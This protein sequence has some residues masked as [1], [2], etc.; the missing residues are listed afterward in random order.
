MRRLKRFFLISVLLL[1]VLLPCFSTSD[2]AKGIYL[3]EEN[4][5]ML[6]T[7]LQEQS[8]DLQTLQLHNQNYQSRIQDLEKLC[9]E[10]ENLLQK[11]EQTLQ[12][13]QQSSTELKNDLLSVNQSLQNALQAVKHEQSRLLVA[14]IGCVVLSVGVAS[15]AFLL[16]YNTVR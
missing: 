5:K 11:Q 15:L 3:S 14:E 9:V 10:K 4:Y 8:I 2:S 12:T 13:M 7:T 16:V 1:Q 6:Q